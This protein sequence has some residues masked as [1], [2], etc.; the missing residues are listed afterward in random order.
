MKKA[1]GYYTVTIYQY[2]PV[3]FLCDI[4]RCDL[5]KKVVSLK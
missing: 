3:K 2:C 5:K 1:F 4:L